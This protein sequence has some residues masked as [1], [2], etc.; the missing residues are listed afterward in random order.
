MRSIFWN[1]VLENNGGEQY[2]MVVALMV[3]ETNIRETP[4]T[5]PH[6]TNYLEDHPT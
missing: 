6:E 3:V 2:L 4:I 1:L 5:P